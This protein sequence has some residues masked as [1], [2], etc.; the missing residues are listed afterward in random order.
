M[1]NKYYQKSKKE[2]I[3]ILNESGMISDE[4]SNNLLDESYYLKDIADNMIENQVATYEI[5]LGIAPNFLING[6]IYAIPMATEE[7]SV[8]AAASYAAA[9]ILKFGGFICSMDKKHLV[10]QII[11]EKYNL[12]F[13]EKLDIEYWKTF[14]KEVYPSL[15]ERGGNLISISYEE[16]YPYCS[17]YV[18]LDT[19]EAMGANMMNTILEAFSLKFE[20]YGFTKLMAILSNDGRNCLVKSSFKIDVTAL[21]NGQ[22][23]GLEIA[24]KIVHANEYAKKDVF[25]ATTHNKGIMNGI[26]AVVLASGN[27]T[28]AIE[29]AVHTYALGKPLTEYKIENNQLY[30]EICVPLNLGTVGGSIKLHPMAK[31]VHEILRYPN[32]KQFAMI[33]ASVGLAQNF[34]A[35]RALVSRGIQHGHMKLHYKSMLLLEGA[36]NEEIELALPILLTKSIKNKKVIQDILTDIRK[37]YA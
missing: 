13:L 11:F 31:I 29:A 35:L 27:D 37:N 36:T 33:V 7:P 5:P 25:R 34:S 4:T 18:T 10:G 3:H 2:R 28:R 24:E 19:L 23:N 8:I 21:S 32:S 17:V 20:E 26:N 6:E 14:A 9:T 12:N 1:F 30:G 15:F 22:L 16:Y